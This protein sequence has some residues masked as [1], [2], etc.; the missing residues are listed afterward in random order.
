MDAIREWKN[1]LALRCSPRTVEGYGW[2]MKQLA[3]WGKERELKNPGDYTEA[4]LTEFLA[5]RRA[6]VGEASIKHM[7]CAYRNFFK[8]ALAEKSPAARLPVKHPK[9]K[10]Q[11]TLSENEA[12]TVLMSF[13]TSTLIGKRD[14]A[15]TALLLDAGLRASEVCRLRVD[16][17][18]LQRRVLLVQVKGGHEKFGLFSAY[19]AACLSAWMAARAIIARPETDTVFVSVG[20]LQRGTPLTRYGLRRLFRETAKRVGVKHFTAHALRRSFA[21]LMI[22]N[23]APT[24]LVQLAGRWESISMVELYTQAID[25]S[26]IDRYSPIGCIMGLSSS[27]NKSGFC[28]EP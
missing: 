9:R 3:A 11:R 28:T 6:Q 5:E 15:L 19:T 2:Q 13:D 25:P 27:A 8:W 14:L 18:D 20:G 16:Q 21:T 22:D 24:R 26:T 17:L 4:R 12:E 10:R 7:V 23:G 1:W